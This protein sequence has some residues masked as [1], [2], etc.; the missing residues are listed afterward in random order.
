MPRDNTMIPV[1]SEY[2][3]I[4]QKMDEQTNKPLVLGKDWVKTR[5]R[6]SCSI[7]HESRQNVELMS[8]T[9]VR[10]GNDL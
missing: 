2:S 7:N 3:L 10:Y 6:C 1:H 4:I 8:L 9:V 5:H